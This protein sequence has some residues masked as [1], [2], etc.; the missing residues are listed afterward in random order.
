MFVD[1]YEGFNGTRY[2]RDPRFIAQKAAQV[3][4]DQGFEKVIGV[5]NWNFLYLTR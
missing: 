5:Q 4:K 2:T 3:A 1:I